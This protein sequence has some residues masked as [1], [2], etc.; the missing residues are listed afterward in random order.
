M[1]TTFPPI[2][3]NDPATRSA[4]AVPLAQRRGAARRE[5]VQA[6]A[7]QRRRGAKLSH[8]I[9]FAD[10]ANDALYRRYAAA[11][12]PPDLTKKISDLGFDCPARLAACKSV[13]RVIDRLGPG[14]DRAG[15][16]RA[17][18][19]RVLLRAK[20]EARR[21]YRLMQH[22]LAMGDPMNQALRHTPSS[23]T[24]SAAASLRSDA[25][26]SYA[27]PS[28]LQSNQ[29]PAAYLRYLY[30]IA[31][32]LDDEIGIRPTAKT[33]LSIDA[34]RPDLA[35]L[36]LSEE[37]LKKEVPTLDLVNDVLRAG[38]GDIDVATSF[39]PIALPY[40]RSATEARTALAQIGGTTFN[41]LAMR[42][43]EM[44]LAVYTPVTWAQDQAGLLGLDGAQDQPAST[45]STLS[46]LIEDRDAAATGPATLEDLFNTDDAATA[47]S[48][49][50][51]MSS[52]DLNFDALAQLF[53]LYS[54]SR[55]WRGAEVSQKEFATAFFNNEDPFE[56]STHE[57]EATIVQAGAPLSV[58]V[59]RSVNY[60]ARLH[61]ATGLPFHV[62]NQI[63][64]V[65]GARAAVATATEGD[66]SHLPSHRLTT[67]GLRVLA[68]YPLYKRAFSLT[69]EAYTALLGEISP[70]WRANEVVEGDTSIA[71]LERTETSFMR[72][73][74]GDDAPYIHGVVSRA[75]TPLSDTDLRTAVS[76]GL[77]V[78]SVEMDKL[79]SV[80]DASFGLTTALDAQGLAAL[81][82]LTTLCRMLGWPL[83]SGLELTQTLSA[84]VENGADLWTAL[85]ARNMSAADTEALCDAMD[86][87]VHLSHWLTEAEMTPDTLVS[88]LSPA[89]ASPQ[90]SDEDALWLG[91]LAT[92]YAPLAAGTDR[93]RTFE[94]WAGENGDDIHISAEDWHTHLTEVDPLY[95]A[96][97]VFLHGLGRDAI[98]EA[99]QSCLAARP[100][101]AL[102]DQSN[103]EQLSS[104]VALLADLRTGQERLMQTR[105]V[106]LS[107]TVNVVS[108]AP[109]IAWAQT[110]ALDLLSDLLP[111]EPDAPVASASLAEIKRYLAVVAAFDLGD[112]DLWLLGQRP[113]WLAPGLADASGRV[114]P[115]GFGQLF[116]LQRFASVQ[117]GAANDAAWRGFFMLT[118]DGAP[119]EGASEDEQTAW[120]V[121]TRTMLA[122][123]M[124][125]TP[126][127]L[128][129]YM[130]AL[131]GAES[132][133]RDI[134]QIDALSRHIRLAEDLRVS[135]KDLLALKDVSR[136]VTAGDWSAAAA[137]AQSALTRT[138]NAEHVTAFRKQMAEHERDAL[139][140]AFLQTKVAR[141]DD[142]G[143]RIKD[144]EG[145]YRHLLLDV[146]VTS[147]VPTSRLVE[148]ISSLQLYISRALSDLE[149]DIVFLDRKALTE[150]WELDK[151]YRQWEANQKLMLYPQNYIEPELRYV[152]SP[153]FETL[154][155]AVS[156]S[157]LDED[158]VESAVNAYMN[159]LASACDLSICGF[160]P[161]RRTGDGGIAN[162]TYHVLAKAKWEPGRFFYRKLDADYLTI[163]ELA[164]SVA[165][166]K[167][168]DWTFWQEVSVPTTFDLLS[169]VTVC[170]FDN[171]FF[172]FWLE[173]EERRD[174]IEGA[175]ST[176]WRIHPRYMRC[177]H[178]ALVGTMLM[179]KLNVTGAL[180]NPAI[181]VLAE[182]AFEWGGAKPNLYGTYQPTYSAA[183]Q[184]ILSVVF[185]INLPG[186]APPPQ[187]NSKTVEARTISEQAT[188]RIRL[189]E[190]W[191][192]AL[193]HLGAGLNMLI[194][195]AAPDDYLP[196]Y[197][198]LDTQNRVVASG[199]V[200][201]G[202]FELTKDTSLYPFGDVHYGHSLRHSKIV[203]TPSTIGSSGLG[204]LTVRLD[205]G[206]RRYTLF[207]SSKYATLLHIR[208]HDEPTRICVRYILQMTDEGGGRFDYET[209]WATYDAQR[210]YL[211]DPNG[212]QPIGSI[213]GKDHDIPFNIET[214]DTIVLPDDWDPDVSKDAKIAVRA[215]IRIQYPIISATYWSYYANDF[216]DTRD[217]PHVEE[218][219]ETVF[220][221][222]FRVFPAKTDIAWSKIG[223]HSTQNFMHLTHS[224]AQ[225]NDQTFV[226][227]N[228][229][230]A[231]SKLARSMPR[232]GGCESL[233]V[234]E[235]QTKPEDLG[236]FFDVYPATLDHIYVD[237]KTELDPARLPT[238]SFDFDSAYGGYGWEI[239]YHLPSA[240]AAGFANSG[241]F[242]LALKWLHKIFDPNADEK[243]QV[244]PL[245]GAT[246]PDGALAFDTGG[247][248][249]DPDRIATDYPFYYQQ[250]TIRQYLETLLNAGDADYEMQTQESLQ[251]AKARYVYARQLFSDNL[252]GTLQTLTNT[253]WQDPTLA[254]V[255]EGNYKG[256]LP[257]Y[258][259]ELRALYEVIEKRLFNLRHWLDLE[260]APMNV[261][262]LAQPIDP[263]ALQKRA[264]A[265]LTMQDEDTAAENPLDLPFDFQYVLKSTKGYINNLKLTSYRLQDVSEKEGDSKME[266]FR[267]ETA[268]LAAE[269]ATKLQGL[270]IR[271]AEKRVDIRQAAVSKATFELAAGLIQLGTVTTLTYSMTADLVMEAA[272]RIFAQISTVTRKIQSRV[273]GTFPNI[274]G[275]SNGGQD[276]STAHVVYS[277]LDLHLFHRDQAFAARLGEI[278]KGWY[279]VAR[280]LQNIERLTLDLSMA[281]LE[282]QEAK[283]GLE[284]EEAVRDSLKSRA[285]RAKGLVGVWESI[286]GGSE[287]YGNFRTSIEELYQ[288]EFDATLDFC[289]LLVKL[290]QD[291]TQQLDGATLLQTTNLGQGVDRFNAP[292][293]LA[294]DVQ[295]LETAYVE[296]LMEQ[297]GQSSEMKF[298]LSE[299][300]ST[301]G[302]RSAL[303]EL[304][305]T[306]ETYFE[307]TDEMFDL[308]YP[309]QFDR[310]IQSVKL[311]FPGLAQAGLNPHAKLT[312]V[313]NIR[314]MTK[315]RA[316]ARGGQ[317]RKDRHALQSL[318][319]GACTVDTNLI[320]APEGCLRRFQN[321]GVASKWHLEIPMIQSLKSRKTRQSGNTAWRDAATRQFANLEP[322]LGEIDMT[323]RFTGRW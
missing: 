170:V 246:D 134:V 175:S 306:G 199:G 205:M 242:D 162:V 82:R 112:I 125:I 190:E 211:G 264:K 166:L 236:T 294:L 167:A 304:V 239:F 208:E 114:K 62:L 66:A 44:D 268:V 266:E 8:K 149:E 171:R 279:D 159:G 137:A 136:S 96:S 150:R 14:V 203:F 142:L 140:A 147:A 23:L 95:R 265:A 210:I 5:R 251:R 230:S 69:P 322:H 133:P 119:A 49:S 103:Q 163:T 320:D 76:R 79:I 309:G 101:I 223:E 272:H 216:E 291:E 191:S 187:D 126:D 102:G 50:H 7:S 228:S 89:Q 180:S 198:G 93:F 141:D 48:V 298:A 179:P 118:N 117:I 124:E 296:A 37:N 220:I 165:Y 312:Q 286:F 52:L 132:V 168:M 105:L 3:A 255:A 41:D 70:F 271:E 25:P 307:L 57:S 54:V 315:D 248:I 287:F 280:N 109:L 46:L 225:T 238:A 155:Q 278:E 202:T 67:T 222:E 45:G 241:Q 310:R 128:H 182:D 61:H 195:D 38:L 196:T 321:T 145:L 115:L 154:L 174:Q 100:G 285:D 177:D 200:I 318:M 40:Q 181:T 207:G 64:K 275:F 36:K 68:S 224:E 122:L 116:W 273:V 212:S 84:Q 127:D 300:P 71:G 129:T 189:A 27:D 227:L 219:D 26:L 235:N 263:R 194:E 158:S 78:S 65:P 247:L 58:P 288:D 55:E 47:S 218:T 130:D 86:W 56:L 63:L 81:Y 311:C 1:N 19:G 31:T 110:T 113:H 106:S 243:W 299:V 92:A 83:L 186:L 157:N 111:T 206:A 302:G 123:L 164:P 178:N 295:R 108:A 24:T 21:G 153:E 314:Y 297:V 16:V 151:D 20:R 97:G 88:L 215:Q 87:L 184:D 34:R 77:G 131:F 301:T 214:N 32:G 53:G 226:L 143:G 183:D 156:G 146:D 160:Y 148:A 120:R 51:L 221:G 42:L 138:H 281:S 323:I 30:R 35:Q 270:T 144:R 229:S 269:N 319:V 204:H 39:H 197:E 169:D 185:G 277:V 284:K 10:M 274:F 192:D 303:E 99:C 28:S 258:N 244:V 188:V 60:L 33:A 213:N 161:E 292:H 18:I 308:F 290:Y 257:P 217:S 73:L 29:S 75:D 98:R 313:S 12:C 289:R 260:G 176:T 15:I 252:S 152:T 104:L 201:D 259:S 193:M 74:F 250:A 17:D 282:L 94:N 254:K 262:L 233:F 91:T 72:A 237:D 317:I 231:L 173:L 9:S 172:F 293:R 80:L 240:I 11:I 249:V 256:F 4:T 267:L 2:S 6:K 261:P 107:G 139:C 232:P 283:L 135:A 276:L 234:P 85:I 209:E 316:Q 13:S 245:R 305:H 90:P 121:Q 22:A 59:L 253:P 43:S